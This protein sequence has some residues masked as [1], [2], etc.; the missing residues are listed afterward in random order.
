MTATPPPP[1][2]RADQFAKLHKV[3]KKH[4][5][6]VAINAER[7][8]ME[9]LLFA[10]C[11]E[12]CRYEAAE[13]AF[14]ALKHTFF[15]WNEVRV[16]SI[17]ELSEVMASLPDPRAAANRV[18]R[19]LHAVFEAR[20]N[21]DIED[22]KKKNIGAALKWLEDLDGTTRSMVSFVIQAALGGHSISIDPAT[23]AIMR[24]LDLISAK[25]AEKGDVPGLERAIPKAKGA[26]FSPLM[27]Q[28][29]ADFKANPFSAAVKSILIEV[30]PEAAGRLPKRRTEAAKKAAE[31][32]PAETA[33]PQAAEPKKGAKKEKEEA[34]AESGRKSAARKKGAAPAKPPATAKKP[35]GKSSPPAKP[36]AATHSP[37]ETAGKK[38]KSASEGLSKRKP[39]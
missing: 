33:K 32:A 5:K 14:A 37:R 13:E 27:H 2:T 18:K 25:E 23:V 30:E 11:L 6:P 4:Y 26:E 22:L 1:I 36:A 28:F 9:H 21:F 17:S 19:V 8:V 31:A 35:K 39:R 16:T 20:F 10:C 24:L 15:D 34:K 12:E 7:T 38:K 29:A 3:L